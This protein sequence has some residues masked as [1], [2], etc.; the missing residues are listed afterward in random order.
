[1]PLAEPNIVQLIVYGKFS[2][3]KLQKLTDAIAFVAPILLPCLKN[4]SK[5]KAMS[6]SVELV[7]NVVALVPVNGRKVHLRLYVLGFPLKSLMKLFI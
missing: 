5:C 6:V 3:K 1:M 4:V 7:N 2:K